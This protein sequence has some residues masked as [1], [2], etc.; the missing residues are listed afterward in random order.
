[1][2]LETRTGAEGAF[3]QRPELQPL[4]DTTLGGSVKG[5][6]TERV[7]QLAR[8]V[9]AASKKSGETNRKTLLGHVQTLHD[10]VKLL[11]K[12][13]ALTAT[14][15]LG[16][17][18]ESSGPVNAEIVQ[19][20]LTAHLDLTEREIDGLIQEGKLKEASR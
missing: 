5:A 1:M 17:I 14:E 3:L 20:S 6:G 8:K 4:V 10:C 16:E 19:E 9:A 15:K 12:K 18:L 7:A 13:E 2:D 11:Q